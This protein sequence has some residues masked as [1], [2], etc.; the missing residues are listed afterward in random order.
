MS[1]ITIQLQDSC[2]CFD[3]DEAIPVLDGSNAAV[4]LGRV[5]D[6]SMQCMQDWQSH[7]SWKLA[8]TAVEPH[9]A[10]TIQRHAADKQ[11]N[12]TRWQLPT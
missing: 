5:S 9:Q 12:M 11:H 1:Y 3:V 4:E 8:E 10:D 2:K 6:L 7:I